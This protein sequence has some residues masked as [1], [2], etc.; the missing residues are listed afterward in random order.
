MSSFMQLLCFDDGYLMNNLYFL[1]GA[2]PG[3]KGAMPPWSRLLVYCIMIDLLIVK[4][5]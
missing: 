3:G 2:D 5:L 1:T 4:L